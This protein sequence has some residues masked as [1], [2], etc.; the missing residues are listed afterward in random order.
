M[1]SR[2][3][4]VATESALNL[5]ARIRRELP[6]FSAEQVDQLADALR[7]LVVSLHPEQIYVFGSQARGTASPASDVDLLV[8][9]PASDEPGHQRDQR[10]YAA[11][12]WPG[13][14]IEV[15]V[16]TREEFAARLPAAASLPATVAREGR[17]LYAA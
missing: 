17:L 5:A 14:P 8:V 15:V 16:L 9:V 3:G 2:G 7:R 1:S 12:S 13:L 11:L 10:A 4:T 6:S